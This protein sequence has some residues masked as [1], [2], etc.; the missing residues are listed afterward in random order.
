MYI[1]VLGPEYIFNSLY[2]YPL[3][4]FKRMAMR[5]VHL[6][7]NFKNAKTKKKINKITLVQ[8]FS[9]MVQH[10]NYAFSWRIQELLQRSSSVLV[11]IYK[12]R[13]ILE[14]MFVYFFLNFQEKLHC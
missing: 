13:Y 3:K 11:S 12:Y 6:P 8:H 5:H 9:P 1:C 7:G 4:A 14:Y 10:F 2:I